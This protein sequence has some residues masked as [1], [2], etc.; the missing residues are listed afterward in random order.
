M[1][2]M[3][4]SESPGLRHLKQALKSSEENVASSVKQ[5]FAMCGLKE[6]THIDAGAAC[7]AYP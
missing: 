2:P 7:H 6:C 5:G 4:K 3:F 1:T